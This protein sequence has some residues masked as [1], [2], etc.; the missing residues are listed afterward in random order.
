MAEDVPLRVARQTKLLPVLGKLIRC[1]GEP[2][3]HVSPPSLE[4]STLMLVPVGMA[5]MM[6]LKSTKST[7]LVSVEVA[8]TTM[9]EVEV[10]VRA[11][12]MDPSP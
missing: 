10:G 7:D 9:E 1:P 4:T 2:A 3:R 12:K 8:P 6:A 5:P 11:S